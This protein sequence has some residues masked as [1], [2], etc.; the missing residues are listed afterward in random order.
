MENR[1]EGGIQGGEMGA[2]RAREGGN[3]VAR[4]VLGTKYNQVAAAAAAA[5]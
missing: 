1:E 2:G 4:L 5:A 3:S